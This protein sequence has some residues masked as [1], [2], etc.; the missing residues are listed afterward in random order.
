M[1][2]RD[3]I[4][5]TDTASYLDII[6][7]RAKA[8]CRVTRTKQ[9]ERILWEGAPGIVFGIRRNDGAYQWGVM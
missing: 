5:V 9:R 3:A 7:N 1:I 8:N 6:A 4:G 2:Q